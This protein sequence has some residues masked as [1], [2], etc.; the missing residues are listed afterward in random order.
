[1]KQCYGVTTKLRE[2]RSGISQQRVSILKQPHPVL[3]PVEE[4]VYT[5]MALR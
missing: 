3:S 5:H 4:A 1:M 2:N